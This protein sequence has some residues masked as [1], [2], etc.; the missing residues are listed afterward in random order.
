[1]VTDNTDYV[2][3][4]RFFVA[5]QTEWS[6]VGSFLIQGPLLGLSPKYA[7]EIKCDLPRV[8]VLL[9]TYALIC[10]DTICI[11]VTWGVFF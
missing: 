7:D 9:T 1:M 10:D 11:Q 8:H 3:C 5:G 6:K 2:L 4:R